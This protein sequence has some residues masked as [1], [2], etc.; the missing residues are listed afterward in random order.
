VGE[1]VGVAISRSEPVKE[2]THFRI[3]PVGIHSNSTAEIIFVDFQMEA[4]DKGT[5][6]QPLC[7][8]KAQ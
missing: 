3:S 2:R 5:A 7:N 1:G 6:I 4:I 8:F